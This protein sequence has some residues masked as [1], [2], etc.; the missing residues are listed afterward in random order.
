[1]ILIAMLNLVNIAMKILWQRPPKKSSRTELMLDWSK[2]EIKLLTN[3]DY[4][5]NEPVSKQKKPKR[6]KSKPK[7]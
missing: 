1:M 4:V 6:T 5:D 7:Q 3:D 2:I